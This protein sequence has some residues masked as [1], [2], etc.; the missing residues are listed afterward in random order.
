MLIVAGYLVVDPVQRD[1]YLE[2][3]RACAARESG[4]LNRDSAVIE[5][6]VTSSTWESRSPRRFPV[7]GQ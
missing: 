4:C 5:P 6:G 7:A 2:D 3:C 1:S